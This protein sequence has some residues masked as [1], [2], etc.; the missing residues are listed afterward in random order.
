MGT[1]HTIHEWRERTEEGEI[2]FLRAWRGQGRWHFL[3]TLKT[4]PD[5]TP[6][7]EPTRE[8]LDALRKKLMDKYQRR[9]VPWEQVEEIDKLIA[10]MEEAAPSHDDEP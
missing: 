8:M 7:P 2:R 5:W 10:R 9:R 1:P 4:D 3:T 6:R